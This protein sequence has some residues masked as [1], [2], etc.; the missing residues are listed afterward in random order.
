M[1]DAVGGTLGRP[2]RGNLRSTINAGRSASEFVAAILALCR[3][4]R[5]ADSVWATLAIDVP[6][7][8]PEPPQPAIHD[9]L[10]I[11]PAP[12]ATRE[13]IDVQ[14]WSHTPAANVVTI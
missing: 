11:D 12:G 9:A 5:P 10:G 13:T 7:A 14:M 4:C 1:L 8:F 6:L 2:W 3:V